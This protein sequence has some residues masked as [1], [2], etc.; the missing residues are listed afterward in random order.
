M[1]Y[2]I[3]TI[4]TCATYITENDYGWNKWKFVGQEIYHNEVAEYGE[5]FF[6]DEILGPRNWK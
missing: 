5:L 1:V 4:K 6:M 3:L 2:K